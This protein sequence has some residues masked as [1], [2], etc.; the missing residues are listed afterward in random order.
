[1]FSVKL[2][3]NHEGWCAIFAC[4]PRVNLFVFVH[5]EK[6]LG[7][8]SSFYLPGL[9]YAFAS[10][11]TITVTYAFTLTSTC[12]YSYILFCTR[13]SNTYGEDLL[14]SFGGLA[15]SPRPERPASGRSRRPALGIKSCVCGE[16]YAPPGR[17]RTD[18]GQCM[19][20]Q[21]SRLSHSFSLV[22]LSFLSFSLLHSLSLV[23]SP[24]PSVTQ[25]RLSHTHIASLTH[26]LPHS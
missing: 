16:R 6:P 19:H 4:R 8:P 14:F 25:L 22:L 18:T 23:F 26:C 7:F 20:H 10:T 12:T 1:M 24:P 11:F 3:F 15:G 21:H 9:T 13:P 5:T 17:L 2:Y